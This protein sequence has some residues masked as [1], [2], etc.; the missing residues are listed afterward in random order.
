MTTMTDVATAHERALVRRRRVEQARG[1]GR[2]LLLAAALVFFLAPVL[3]IAMTAFKTQREVFSFPPVFI[4]E[5][6]DL[7]HFRAT[8]SGT[9]GRAL[10]DSMIVAT[11][12]TGLSLLVGVPAAYAISRFRIG[13]AHLP[14][15]ILSIRMFPPVVA[16]IPLFLL[17]RQIGL[18]DSY[19][20]L[21]LA[22]LTFNVPFVVWMMKGFFDDLP[23]ELEDAALVDG[24]N[25]WQAFVRIALPL[26]VPGLVSTALLC[27]IFAW[28]EF[29]MA[30]FLTR[31]NVITLP[32][33]LS[34]LVGGSQIL[35]G[36]IG[37]LAIV[38]II[39]VVLI[40][41]LLQR[42][43]VR[44]LTLGAVKG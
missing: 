16:A 29:L 27:F 10:R 40:A 8:L 21:T 12:A 41:I 11:S 23:R 43:V 37:A 34:S 38:A 7:R 26:A 5:T 9:G 32:V 4:P 36:Q 3:W 24:A 2:T 1:V 19:L 14:L 28:N 6:I 39:P 25:R 22:Y 13:G 17:Y 33:A 31:S 18:L 42:Y 44:G 15:W 35:W 30:L 20:G